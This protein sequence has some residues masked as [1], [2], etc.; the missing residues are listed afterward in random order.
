LH[1]NLLE[2]GQNK[3]DR[4]LISCPS[5]LISRSLAGLVGET[6]KAIGGG[7]VTLFKFGGDKFGF[8]LFKVPKT[9][10]LA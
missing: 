5:D 6:I 9:G 2:N 8:L 10:L 1:K 3:M 4:V 7:L